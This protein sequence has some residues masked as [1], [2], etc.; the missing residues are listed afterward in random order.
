MFR[1]LGLF[2][3]ALPLLFAIPSTSKAC[4]FN[5]EN[6]NNGTS[7]KIPSGS[8]LEGYQDIISGK[9]PK[10]FTITGKLFVPG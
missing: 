2:I 6:A 1:V 5:Y 9:Q 3:T 8:G 7:V 10:P 4:S